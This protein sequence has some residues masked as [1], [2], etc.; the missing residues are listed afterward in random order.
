MSMLA[1]IAAWAIAANAA[2]PL[3]AARLAPPDASAV[4]QVRGGLEGRSAGMRT[5]VAGVRSLVDSMG[6]GE[7]WAA[8]AAMARL[9]PEAL[10]KRCAGRDASLVVRAERGGAAWV[11]ALE[12]KSADACDLLRSLGGRMKGAQRFELPQLGLAGS[13][14][15]DW[16]LVTDRADS[17]L[18]RDMLRASSE[19]GQPTLADELPPIS[20]DSDAAITVALRHDRLATGVS[21]WSLSEEAGRV[22][23]RVRA[24]LEGEALG[25]LRDEVEPVFALGSLPEET[26]ASWV[27]PM[28][29]HA[30][31]AALRGACFDAEQADATL[32]AR[33]AVAI[34]PPRDADG[35][36]AI[37]VAYELTDAA[38]GTRAHDALIDRMA[39]S[40][41]ARAGRAAELHPSRIG[42]PVESPRTC[43]EPG[44]AQAAFAGIEP[45]GQPELFART[46]VLAKGGWRV[47]ASDRCWLDRVAAAL[48]EQPVAAQALA[49][50]PH[51]TRVG[52]LDG[53]LLAR[54]LERWAG[55]RERQHA[56]AKPLQLLSAVVRNAGEVSWRVADHG[57]GLVEAQMEIDPALDASLD[58]AAL[59]GLSKLPLP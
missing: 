25:G 43:D 50:P 11:L 51:W 22:R 26:I 28:P 46:V 39:V 58:G 59:A 8:A 35:A 21:V 9:S 52:R 13:V 42:R 10:L 20:S 29:V 56:C 48:E 53:G 34:G 7:R 41:A 15:G 12:M 24:S 30:V 17:A 23:V 38:A 33:L 6:A 4:I 44:V 54:A 3:A 1:T 2:P 40:I 57:A 55:E 36:V 49:G 31:P 19:P 27:Q 18:L 47:Y 14:S 5:L 37:A 45:V 16:L 32:G